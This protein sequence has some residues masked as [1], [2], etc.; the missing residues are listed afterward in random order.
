MQKISLTKFLPGIIWFIIIMVLICTPGNDLPKVDDWFKIIYG[1]KCIHAIMFGMLAYLFIYPIKKT[2]FSQIE[3]LHYIIRICIVASIWGLTTEFIQ[4]YF[5]PY[6]S[7]DILDW[8]ADS[9]GIFIT[10]LFCRKWAKK[11]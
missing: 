8:A 5:I 9:L 2:N 11:S 3:K 6:R 4:K 7:F 1:D 10:Y